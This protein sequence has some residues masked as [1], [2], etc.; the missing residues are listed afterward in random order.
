MKGCVNLGQE[1][2]QEQNVLA[3][4]LNFYLEVVSVITQ[5]EKQL[6]QV[7][8]CKFYHEMTFHFHFL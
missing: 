6:V 3:Q 5:N 2:Y 1:H 4:L 8:H 7:S